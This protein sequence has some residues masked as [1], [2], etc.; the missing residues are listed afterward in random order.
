M[1]SPT[2]P[3]PRVLLTS[4]L[5]TVTYDAGLTLL[6]SSRLAALEALETTA[7]VP[8]RL[9]VLEHPSTITIGRRGAPSDVLLGAPDLERFEVA[10]RRTDRGGEVTWH[11]PGQL[12]AYPVVHLPSLGVRVPDFVEALADAAVAALAH[13][14]LV[15]R[16]DADRPGVWVGSLKIASLG[17]RVAH[18]VTSHGLALNVHNSLVPFGWI[19]PCR[20]QGATMTSMAQ[21]LDGREPPSV[22][23]VGRELAHHLAR[24]LSLDLRWETRGSRR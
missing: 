13:W 20:A 18:G 19:I 24:L 14:G 17:L 21:Q 12:V 16:Y 10:V 23:A 3:E 1:P 6:E 15:G 8:Q 2:S 5:G 7:P 4:S 9:F 22:E 11:G